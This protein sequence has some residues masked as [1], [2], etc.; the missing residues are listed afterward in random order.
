[1]LRNP[2]ILALSLLL[3]AT[4]ATGCGSKDGE[5]R[6]N[7]G[8][9]TFIYPMMSKWSSEYEKAK[10]VKVNYQSI[11]SGGGIQQ[12]TAKTFDFG[13]SDAPMND[14]QLKKAKETGG[15]VVHIPLAM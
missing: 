15:E 7:G 11:G 14:E 1:M 9:A 8:G 5:K 3:G 13:C 6:L 10:G 2:T 12:M 4:L